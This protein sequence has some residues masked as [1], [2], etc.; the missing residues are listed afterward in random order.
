MSGHV[1]QASLDASAALLRWLDAMPLD[2]N[3]GTLAAAPGAASAPHGQDWQGWLEQA[4][5]ITDLESGLAAL[6]R[7]ETEPLRR[8]RAAMALGYVG[9]GGTSGGRSSGENA[10]AALRAA[11]AG[12]VAL[13]A[14]EAAA[15]LGRRGR[16]S[17]VA[18]LCAALGH[19]DANV[20]A[21]ACTALGNLG[22]SAAQAGLRAA[23]ADDDAYVRAAATDALHRLTGGTMTPL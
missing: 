23:S 10:S 11:L 4:R 9:D 8:S 7:S 5:L 1:Q 17:D 6:L 21:N 2:D 20:R 16:T 13:V 19:A 14:M 3:P 12:D 22:G 18:A 15:A